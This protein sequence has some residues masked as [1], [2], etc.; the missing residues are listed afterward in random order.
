MRP[1]QSLVSQL[2]CVVLSPLIPRCA[3]RHNFRSKFGLRNYSTTKQASSSLKPTP[4]KTTLPKQAAKA[5]VTPRKS[6]KPVAA[7]PAV[8]YSPSQTWKPTAQKAAPE[9]V[10]IYHAGTGRIVFLG[11]LRTAT[12][13]VAG[14]SA[15]IIAPAF[16]A[17]EFPSYL[18]PL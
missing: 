6:V 3:S 12:I 13:F 4:S 7:K 17:D 1:S 8:K 14:V 16:F 15:M 5:N 10:L 18:A 2:R 11:M 9:N